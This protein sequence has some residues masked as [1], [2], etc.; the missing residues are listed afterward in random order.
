MTTTKDMIERARSWVA[1]T[2][3]DH[4]KAHHILDADA[5]HHSEAA[6]DAE[7]DGDTRAAERLRRDAAL[8]CAARDALDA[9]PALVA[10]IDRLTRVLAE[11]G[12]A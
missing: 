3:D 11:R 10:E 4:E 8:C 9:V 2:T 7:D 6:E 1:R 12:A 5:D